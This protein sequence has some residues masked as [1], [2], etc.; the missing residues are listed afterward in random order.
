MNKPFIPV[1]HSIPSGAALIGTVLDKYPINK[2]CSCK[3][4]K[5]G[6]NDTYLV[7]TEEEKYILRVYRRGWR[8]KQEI[9]F[10]LELLSFL[11]EQKQPV[12]YP[13]TRIDGGLTTEIA[14]PEGKRYVAVFSY[15]SG[16]AVDGKLDTKQSYILGEVLAEIHQVLNSFKSSFSRP[17]LNNEYLLDWS[18]R[19]ITPLYQYRKKDLDFFQQKIDNIKNQI[20]ELKLTLLAPGYGI[21]IGDVHSGNANF[22]KQNEP[23]LFDFD[24]CGYGWRAFDIA[25]FLHAALR[26]KI[27]VTVK[28]SFVE[29]YQAI[30]KLSESEL[31]SIPVFIKAA[32]IWV[33]GI[34]TNVVGDVLPYGW[35]TDDWLDERLA[36]LKILDN[37][38]SDNFIT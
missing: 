8:N 18:I 15:A 14:A 34:S 27:D 33:M 22:T 21:C 2:L 7:E 32:H 11:H 35:F 24:Q 20:A 10:E 38:E 6:L 13:I 31:T 19:S 29:G 17:I 28:N 4:Y 1:I 26:M 5:R 12:A 30:R 36:M 23:T 16:Y 25:K 3:L 37:V 9:D